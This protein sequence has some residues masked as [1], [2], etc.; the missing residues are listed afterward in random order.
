MRTDRPMSEYE[1]ALASIC[2]VICSVLI[3]LGA[4]Q[5]TLVYR[6]SE[7]RKDCIERGSTNSAATIEIAIQSIVDEWYRSKE[8]HRSR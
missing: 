3:D 8:W 6:L 1:S 2:R 4:D 5:H 7:A